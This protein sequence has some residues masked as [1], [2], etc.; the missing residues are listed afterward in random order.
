MKSSNR[1]VA[2][3]ALALMTATATAAAATHAG[4]PDK[5]AAQTQ[6]A[7]PAPE[8][9]YRH[10]TTDQLGALAHALAAHGFENGAGACW[11]DAMRA[12]VRAFQKKTGLSPTGFPNESTRKA[13]GL[14]W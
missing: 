7:M 8:C 12:A 9:R 11:N 6:T 13:L 2:G 14:D 4:S 10:W 5:P 3:I 1:I